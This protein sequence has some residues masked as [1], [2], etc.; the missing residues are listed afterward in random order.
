M[1]CGVAGGMLAL[2]DTSFTASLASIDEVRFSFVCVF[3]LVTFA[4][5]CGDY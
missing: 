3:F 4:V 5:F 2:A 1:I